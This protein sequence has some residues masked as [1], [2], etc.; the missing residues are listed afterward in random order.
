[1][2]RKK[3]PQMMYLAVFRMG[4]FGA[5]REWGGGGGVGKKV[6]LTIIYH[7]YPTTM[8]IRTGIPYL[9]KIQNLYKLR[10]TPLNS[11]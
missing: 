2:T 10:E 1:M 6:S 3:N 8:K 5:C 4:L 9:K 7:T 11:A